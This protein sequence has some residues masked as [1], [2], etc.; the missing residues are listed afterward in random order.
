MTSHLKI[1]KFDEESIVDDEISITIEDNRYDNDDIEWVEC[2]DCIQ[3][4]MI[5]IISILIIGTILLVLI[6]TINT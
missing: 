3:R 1:N 4:K 6:Y 5:C 2:M